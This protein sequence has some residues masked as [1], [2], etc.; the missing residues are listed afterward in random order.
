MSKQ[1]FRA[2]FA[3]SIMRWRRRL[4]MSAEEFGEFVG[5][6]KGT[7]LNY[8]NGR[9]VPSLYSAMRIAETLGISLDDLI[10]GE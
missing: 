6:S 7:I 1:E 2:N 10:R 8:E 4:R 9:C 5:A 3:Y